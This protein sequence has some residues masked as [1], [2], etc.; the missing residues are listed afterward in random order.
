MEHIV[1]ITY[2]THDRKAQFRLL[3]KIQSK[4][5]YIALQLSVPVDTVDGRNDEDKCWDVMTKWL[6]RGSLRYEVNW[7]SLVEVLQK[8]QMKT[9]ADELKKALDNQIL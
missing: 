4:W 8:I 6:Q 1:L 5:K 9:V 2:Q 7:G 3:E